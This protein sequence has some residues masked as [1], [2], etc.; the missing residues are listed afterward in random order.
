MKGR[1]R[2]LVVLNREYGARLADLAQT[3]PVWIVDTPPNRGVAESIWA[4]APGR[5]HLGG[6]TTFKFAPESSDQDILISQL[7]T[8]DLHHGEYSS[9][10]PYT[11]LEIIGTH[12]TSRLKAE[13]SEFGFHEFEET[14]DGF[15]ALRPLPSN[16]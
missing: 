3:G 8:I 15:R 2:V 11:I 1:Y 4:A 6:V 9:D 12:L 14:S 5:S 7:N 10:P 16:D 13:L